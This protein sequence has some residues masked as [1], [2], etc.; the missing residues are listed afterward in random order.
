VPAL[1]AGDPRH[2]APAGALAVLRLAALPAVGC[3]GVVR[4]WRGF[5]GS[6]ALRRALARF[7]LASA[8]FGVLLLSSHRVESR[9][10]EDLPST[11]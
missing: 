3:G 7:F 6:R 10:A 2:D 9:R 8:V 11:A 4:P 5:F 1:R